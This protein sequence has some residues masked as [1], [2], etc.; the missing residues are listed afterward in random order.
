[1]KF[2]FRKLLQNDGWLENVS[3]ETDEKGLIISIEEN[4][5]NAE[6]SS[7]IALPGFQN[8]HSHAFQYAM[9]GIAENHPTNDVQ[10]DFWNWRDAM[11]RLALSVDPDQFEAIATMLYAELLRH[12]Y[13]NVAEFHYV[14]HGTNGKPYDNLAEM[15]SQLINAAKTAGISITLVPIFYQNGGFDQP[16]EQNQKRFIS[17]TFDDY[18]KLYESTEIACKYYKNANIGIGIHSMRG[19]APETIMEVASNFPSDVPFHIHISE[20]LKEVDD[21]QNYLGKRPV[22][23]MLDNINLSDRFHFVHA[24]H[25]NVAEIK[26]LAD[27]QVNVVLC[28]ST[29]GNLGDGVFPLQ[30]FQ[31]HGGN[32]SIG[33]DSHV[34]LNPFEE[35]RLLDYGQRLTSHRRSIF[36]NGTNGN[37]GTFA[38]KQTTKAGRKAMNDSQADYFTVGSPLNACLIGADHPLISTASPENILNTLIYSS[39]AT[40]QC[41]TIANG[42][43][44]VENGCH[45]EYESIVSEFVDAIGELKNR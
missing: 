18:A 43:W 35:L 23:W 22:E 4:C 15:G 13:T 3:V 8:A 11:Y 42:V 19:V 27:H 30:Q 1:M 26:G 24:T 25:I 29:E 39:D 7:Y 31:K 9:A 36:S 21:C 20:Q 2:Q 45:A 12:G 44:K 34:G 10:N 28:P 33:T 14:H 38:I 32:W 37:S 40:T 16:P 5:E 6:F 17:K 41:G